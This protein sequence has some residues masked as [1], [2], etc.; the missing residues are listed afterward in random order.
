MSVLSG[1]WRDDGHVPARVGT[2]C[3][4]TALTKAAAKHEA[5]PGKINLWLGD[6]LLQ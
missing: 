6:V 2:A 3:P 4:P 1:T 5:V